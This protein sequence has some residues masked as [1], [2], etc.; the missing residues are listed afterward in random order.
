MDPSDVRDVEP[1]SADIFLARMGTC[2]GHDGAGCERCSSQPRDESCESSGPLFERSGLGLRMG[3]GPSNRNHAKRYGQHGEKKVRLHE[4]GV[5]V[6]TNRDAS[7]YAVGEHRDEHTDCWP[8]ES[9]TSRALTERCDRKEQRRDADQ[10]AE[11]PVGLLD[12][13]VSGRHVNE[14][15]GVAIRPVVATKPTS[16][17]ANNATC[18]HQHTDANSRDN[19]Q[20]A[21][22]VESS[23][24]AT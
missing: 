17:E 21:I 9:E 12:C 18:N 22:S 13:R 14:T 6:R 5:E 8:A 11:H 4:G 24:P 7:D 23:E 19:R 2:P 3:V 10:P 16:G 20:P 1:E 15:F